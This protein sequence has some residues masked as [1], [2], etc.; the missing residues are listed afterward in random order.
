MARSLRLKTIAEGVETLDQVDWLLKRGV[1]F[2]Q[3]WHFARAMPPQEFIQWLAKSPILLRP[4][5]R[6]SSGG[7]LMTV[8]AGSAIE[9]PAEH[10]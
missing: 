1:Q 8:V 7:N 5:A 10:P 4:P 6:R 2:C 9:L 3:G